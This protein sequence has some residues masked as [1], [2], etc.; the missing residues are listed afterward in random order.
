MIRRLASKTALAAALCAPV[1]AMAAAPVI[2]VFKSASCGCCTAWVEHLK[3]NGFK[4]RVVNVDNPSDYRE[5]GGIPN[6]LGSCHTGMV[7]GYAIEGHIPASDIKR[8]LAEKPKAKGLAVPAMPL[9]SPGM[10]GPRK[11]PFDVLL[12]QVNGSTKVF[13]HYN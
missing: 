6:E 5:R 13:K 11:D 10:E 8:L 2:D 3:S 7:G 12:V 9:G 4:T 1:L